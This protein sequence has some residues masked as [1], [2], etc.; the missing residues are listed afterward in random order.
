MSGF[1]RSLPDLMV[2]RQNHA[3]AGYLDIDDQKVNN[4]GAGDAQSCEIMG[5][6][7]INIKCYL[8]TDYRLVALQF[9]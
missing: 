5:F 7:V 1:E 3:C 9:D 4:V 2:G 8:V 6:F